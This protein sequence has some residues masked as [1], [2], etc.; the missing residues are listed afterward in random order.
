MNLDDLTIEEEEEEA[1]EDPFAEEFME[2]LELLEMC[3]VQFRLLCVKHS[4]V[5][6]PGRLL[7]V[8]KLRSDVLQ[9]VATFTSVEE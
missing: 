8:D 5:I 3:A 4:D 2:A 7:F 1:D 6:E 9:F